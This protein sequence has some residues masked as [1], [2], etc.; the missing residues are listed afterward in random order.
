MTARDET[1]GDRN[2]NQD[3]GSD[4]EP[5]GAPS[6][7]TLALRKQRPEIVQGFLLIQRAQHGK[8]LPCGIR[9][10]AVVAQVVNLSSI[11]AFVIGTWTDPVG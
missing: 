1:Q 9:L 3:D 2:G 7:T 6:A 5:C 11:R 10:I 4:K 8:N